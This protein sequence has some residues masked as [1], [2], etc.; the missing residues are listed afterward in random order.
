MRFGVLA[1]AGLLALPAVAAAQNEAGFAAEPPAELVPFTRFAI[2][3]WVGFRVPYGSGEYFVFTETGGQQFQLDE[4]RGGGVAVGL[5]AAYQLRG[6]LNL[7]G[8]VAYSAADEDQLTVLQE[9]GTSKLYQ[10]DG[11][12]IWFVKAGLQYR[13]PD[14]IPDNR[15]FHPAAYVTVAPAMVFA[16]YPDVEGLDDDDVNGSSRNFA[17]NLGVDAA[18]NLGS[19]GLTLTFALEDYITFW[20]QDRIRVRDEVLLGDLFED[21]V[22]L[23]YDTPASNILMLR[24]GVSWRF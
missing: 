13:L 12:E 9:D 20:D 16:D 17:L 2:T 15:R 19:R 4:D 14:P 1:L 23:E 3:P 7:V 22:I 18:T 11:P 21:D 6:P 10:A 8:G 24:A 5:D